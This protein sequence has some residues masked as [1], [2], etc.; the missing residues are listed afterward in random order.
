MMTTMINSINQPNSHMTHNRL[1][2][3]TCAN[4]FNKII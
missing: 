2:S 3:S 1:F 4:R